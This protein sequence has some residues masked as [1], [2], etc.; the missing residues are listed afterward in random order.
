MQTKYVYSSHYNIDE[1]AKSEFFFFSC[2]MNE[3]HNQY[4]PWHCSPI[5]ITFLVTR[6]KIMLHCCRWLLAKAMKRIRQKV[7]KKSSLM[8]GKSAERHC[9]MLMSFTKLEQ[10][11]VNFRGGR[12]IECNLHLLKHE[13][14]LILSVSRRPIY[15][16]EKK[17]ASLI[18]AVL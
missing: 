2:V 13:V 18:G 16:Y 15:S 7:T 3:S 12:L 11:Q 9:S 6:F 14:S 17:M 4:A 5:L 1:K 10:T 8:T